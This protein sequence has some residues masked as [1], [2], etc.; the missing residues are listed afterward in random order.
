MKLEELEDKMLKMLVYE[1][2]KKPSRTSDNIIEVLTES[3]SAVRRL[4]RLELVGVQDLQPKYMTD[5]ET[6]R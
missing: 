6:I 2:R 5:S 4:R 1:K 3:I